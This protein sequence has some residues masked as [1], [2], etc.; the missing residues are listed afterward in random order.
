M[1][2]TPPTGG[3]PG[4]E[5]SCLV[6]LDLKLNASM[7][8]RSLSNWNEWLSNWDSRL[9]ALTNKSQD[10]N[11]TLGGHE[12]RMMSEKNNSSNMKC[13]V[14]WGMNDDAHGVFPKIHPKK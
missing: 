5:V 11:T 2:P 8:Q 6:A 9:E 4:S 3:A 14:I 13:E 10:I 7:L 1:V 12:S